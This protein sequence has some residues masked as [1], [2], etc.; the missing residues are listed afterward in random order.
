MIGS[1]EGA[2]L[3]YVDIHPNSVIPG[4]CDSGTVTPVRSKFKI[5]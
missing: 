5:L 3:R 1:K 2:N 4:T